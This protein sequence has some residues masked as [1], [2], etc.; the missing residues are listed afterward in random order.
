MLSGSQ[1]SGGL[2]VLARAQV[3]E[4]SAP[5][6]Y[7]FGAARDGIVYNHRV[8]WELYGPNP[9]DHQFLTAD[10]LAP[11]ARP[12]GSAADVKVKFKLTQRGSY[13]LRA[14]TVDTAGRSTVVW[15]SV[16]VSQD[17]S[18]GLLRMRSGGSP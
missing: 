18:I 6:Y 12:S 8:A 15:K 17:T 3:V 13:R 1:V 4:T 10:N 14:A 7:T 16:F 2:G 5:V 11:A 9:E